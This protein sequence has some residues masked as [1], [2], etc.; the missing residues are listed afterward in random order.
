MPQALEKVDAYISAKPG[1]A[2][3][4]SCAKGLILTELG[5][6]ADAIAVFTG[7]TEDFPELPE[8]YNNLAVLTHS[9]NS[10]T[11][12]APRSKWRFAPIQAT[13][14]RTRTSAT[15]PSWP[16]RPTT[17]RCNSTRRTLRRR[18]SFR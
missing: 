13:P 16:A 18:P 2:G 9:R 17:R 8:P 15:T 1:R 7:L 14:S 10:T 5:R 11:R 3:G 6:S 4:V 12:R